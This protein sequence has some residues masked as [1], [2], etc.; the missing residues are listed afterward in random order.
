ME[1][2]GALKQVQPLWQE[3]KLWAF[4][5]DVAEGQASAHPSLQLPSLPGMASGQSPSPWSAVPSPSFFCSPHS[6]VLRFQSPD[7]PLVFLSPQSLV[8]DLQLIVLV[9]TPLSHYQSLVMVLSFDI[10]GALSPV[11]SP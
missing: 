2:P 3:Q 4:A 7:S 9:P 11:F 1:G 8:S 5:L 6:P 10:P